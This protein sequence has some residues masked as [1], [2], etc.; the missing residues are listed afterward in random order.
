MDFDRLL[1]HTEAPVWSVANVP[2]SPDSPAVS[3]LAWPPA[4]GEAQGLLT[5]LRSVIADGYRVVVC[6][7]SDGSAARLDK[8]LARTGSPSRSSTAATAHSAPS[9]APPEVGSW[10]PR[11]TVG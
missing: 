1:R 2:D 5:Q 7:D 3:A 9:C 11:S 10:W 8:L 6:A 4:V